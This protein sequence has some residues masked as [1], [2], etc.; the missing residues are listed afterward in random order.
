MKGKLYKT[1]EKTQQCLNRPVTL[2]G[3]RVSTAQNTGLTDMDLHDVDVYYCVCVCVCV[4]V[5]VRAC[6]CVRARARGR[7][8]EKMARYL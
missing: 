7:W 6:V 1:T 3:N 2:R 8:R 5:R 4:C